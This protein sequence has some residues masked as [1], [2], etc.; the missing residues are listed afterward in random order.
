MRSLTYTTQAA[1]HH[2]FMLDSQKPFEYLS[3]EAFRK[4]TP[5]QKQEY[6]KALKDHLDVPIGEDP[7]P[8]SSS[9]AGPA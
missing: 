5:H 7:P 9:S 1:A 4:L 2:P 3:V 8:Q 6:V